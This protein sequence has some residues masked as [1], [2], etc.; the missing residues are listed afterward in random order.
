MTHLCRFLLYVY[1]VGP[2]VPGDLKTLT[3]WQARKWFQVAMSPYG[4]VYDLSPWA[5]RQAALPRRGRLG[6][7]TLETRLQWR[8][9]YEH[10]VHAGLTPVVLEGRLLLLKPDGTPLEPP[11]KTRKDHLVSRAWSWWKIQHPKPLTL[12][13]LQLVD[14]DLHAQ[15]LCQLAEALG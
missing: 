11:P 3:P 6:A 12:P 4:P 2:L 9:V 14:L 10:L 15:R 5:I 8:A 7:R 1:L 13:P